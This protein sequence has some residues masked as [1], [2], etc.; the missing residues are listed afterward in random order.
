[1]GIWLS[2]LLLSRRFADT[3]TCHAPVARSCW[4]R[5]LCAGTARGRAGVPG[6]AH[7]PSG[8]WSG[9]IQLGSPAGKLHCPCCLTTGRIC[10]A[11]CH[12]SCAERAQAWV[13]ISAQV[14]IPEPAAR[15]CSIICIFEAQAI[16]FHLLLHCFLQTSS[17]LGLQ[18]VKFCRLVYQ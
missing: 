18:N 11:V 4:D 12:C 10:R 8:C 14:L 2:H 7:F 6:E 15:F 3:P 5:G 17:D 9:K 1:M 13:F 16:T